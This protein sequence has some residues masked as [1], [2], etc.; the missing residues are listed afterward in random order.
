MNDLKPAPAVRPIPRTDRSS[1]LVNQENV[2]TLIQEALARSHQQEAQRVAA[3]HRLARRYTAGRG[4]T[5]L[6]SWAASRA[7][8]ARLRAG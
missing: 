8:R 3:E 2:M 1:H 4:W 7:E 6:A 5:R